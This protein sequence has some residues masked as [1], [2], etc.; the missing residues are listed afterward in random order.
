MQPECP[1]PKKARYATRGA[2]DG[3]ATRVGFTYSVTLRVYECVCTWFHLTSQPAP[4]VAVA[5][6]ARI[7]YISALPDLHFREIVALDAQSKA[8]PVD[9]AALRARI[10]L[11]RWND[12]LGQLIKDIESQMGERRHEKSLEAYD[13]RKRALGYRTTLISRRTECQKLRADAHEQTMRNNDSRLL[14]AQ[15]AAAAGATVQELR[16]AAGEV[17][18]DR[19]IDAHGVEFSG[20]LAEAYQALGISLPD[21]VQK[22]L[23]E[24]HDR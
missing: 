16:A 1:T 20:Y 12:F 9:S 14:D 7:Q 10:N 17:A 21:R 19:L 13:W 23:E 4:V 8:V 15:R 11:K 18:V 5:D 22:H 3:A 6:T 2:A 24:P